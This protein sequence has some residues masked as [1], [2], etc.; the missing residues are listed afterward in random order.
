[1]YA[2][3]SI[4]LGLASML[5]Y[6]FANAYSRPL[7]LSVGAAQTL[8]LRGFTIC[9]VLL[10][11][12]IP[13]LIARPNL[14]AVAGAFGLGLLGYIPVLA[15]TH[16]IKISRLGVVAPIAGTSPLVTVL[17]AFLFLGTHITAVGWIAIVVV[18]I[19]NIAVSVDP[20]NW[21]QSKLLK[22][23]SGVPFALIAAI[24][25]GLFFF[26]FIYVT[27]SLGPWLGSLITEIG[28]TTAAGIHIWLTHQKVALQDARKPAIMVN[29]LLV[30]G[31]TL[32]FAI[33]VN[34]YS[35]SIVTVLSNST[36]LVSAILGATLFNERLTR[37]ELIAGAGMIIG[38]SLIALS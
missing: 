28:V 35:V 17:L 27:R 9:G 10:V 25:W 11:A 26:G 5:A 33:G 13:S 4:A 30:G 29:A 15:F 3:I 22:L 34:H 37:L 16:G 7:S 18:V 20:S 6:G 14:T 19:A 8:F 24:G 2:L 12:A 21:R 36:A 32:A 1:M 23:G 38:V 31:G